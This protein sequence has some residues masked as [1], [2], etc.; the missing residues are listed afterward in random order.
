MGRRGS[1]FLS[2]PRVISC[3]A[4]SLPVTRLSLPVP[5]H[6]HFRSPLG[7]FLSSRVTSC[8]PGHF[9]SQSMVT[10]CPPMVTSCPATSRPR[11]LQAPHTHRP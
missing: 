10:S 2:T 11:P 4:E 1:H 3:P 6:S 7:H 5:P 9:L 8:P